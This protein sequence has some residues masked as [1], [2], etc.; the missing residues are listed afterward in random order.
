[1]PYF[2]EVGWMVYGHSMDDE[3]LLSFKG[4]VTNSNGLR[5]GRKQN[6]RD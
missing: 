2:Q 4:L 5:S 6:K 1:M 3:C